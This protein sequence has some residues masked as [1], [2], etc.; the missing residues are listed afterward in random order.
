MEKGNIG[1]FAIIWLSRR[2]LDFFICP[3]FQVPRSLERNLSRPLLIFCFDATPKLS[4]WNPRPQ[5]HTC[6]T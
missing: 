4:K 2:Q 3:P 5:Q 6:S 1:A